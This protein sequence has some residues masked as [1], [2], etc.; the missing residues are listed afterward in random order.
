MAW[1]RDWGRGGR[2]VGILELL[3]LLDLGERVGRA[4]RCDRSNRVGEGVHV[5]G[6]VSVGVVGV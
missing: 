1:G 4:N 5:M 3:H 2:E 6:S